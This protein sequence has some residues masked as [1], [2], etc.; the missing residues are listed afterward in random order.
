MCK[1]K[2]KADLKNLLEFLRNSVC[3]CELLKPTYVRM[4]AYVYNAVSI[5]N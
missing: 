5:R 4:C 3:F 2:T 1:K